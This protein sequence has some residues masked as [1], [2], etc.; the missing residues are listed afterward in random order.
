VFTRRARIEIPTHKVL[1][2]IKTSRKGGD[3]LS[4]TG[5]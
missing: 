5:L 3:D 2:C 1:R 4:A